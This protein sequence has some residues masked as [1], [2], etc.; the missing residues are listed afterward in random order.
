MS[1]HNHRLA[2]ENRGKNPS[3]PINSPFTRWHTTRRV[4]TLDWIGGSKSTRNLGSKSSCK[5]N[6]QVGT[7]FLS[8]FVLQELRVTS[9]VTTRP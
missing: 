7:M 2:Y 6:M 3:Q 1:I 4:V 9:S 5:L 8:C